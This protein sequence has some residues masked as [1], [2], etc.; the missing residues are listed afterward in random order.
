MT[1]QMANDK[2]QMAHGKSR[3]TCPSKHT[4]EGLSLNTRG[5]MLHGYSALKVPPASRRPVPARRRRYFRRTWVSRRPVMTQH[6]G[7]PFYNTAKKV[8]RF[9]LNLIVCL[10]LSS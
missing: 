8:G 5:Q 4:G 1:S 9:L 2:W 7:T 3:S 10:L 6:D